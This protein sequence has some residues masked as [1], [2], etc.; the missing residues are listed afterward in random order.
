MK[1]LVIPAVLSRHAEE[2]AFLWLLRD[3]AVARPQYTLDTLAELDQRVEAHLD[4][5]RV[6]G[7]IGAHLTNDQFLEFPEP[8]EAFTAALL[9]LEVASADT[10]QVLFEAAEVSP[11]IAQ[12]DRVRSR[13]VDGRRGGPRPPDAARLG[14]AQRLAHRPGRHGHPTDAD[15]RAS[16]GRWPTRSGMPARAIKAIGEMGDTGD[17]PQPGNT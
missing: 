11:G 3:R 15:S 14:H 7:E 6:A 13:V 1:P 4:G 10:I 5:L 9:A 16:T 12:S 17:S 2:A 8:G